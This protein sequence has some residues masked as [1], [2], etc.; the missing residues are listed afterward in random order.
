ARAALLIAL[1]DLG[2]IWALEEVTGALT[3]LADASISAAA[4]WLL[5]LEL[6]AGRLPGIDESALESG[7]GYILLAMGKLG[8]RELNFSSD[9]DLIAL[10]DDECFDGP[11][12]M[13]ARARY[14]HVTRQ[15][16]RML[17]ENTEDGYVFRTD[18]RLR[19]SPSTTPI[20]L[21]VSAAERYYEAE[22]R[23]W[24]RAAHIKARP[25]IDRRAGAAYLRTLQPFIW[26]RHLDFAAIEDAHDMLDR[27]REQKARF[28][29]GALPGHDVKLGPGGIREIEFFAQTRQLIMGGRDE[30]M[31]VPTTLGALDAL[32]A[33]GQ[34]APETRDTL[35][36]DYR[37]L[38][39]IE[40]RL[41]MIEDAQTHLIPKTSEAR[42]R[43]A[44][45]AGEDQPG[46][47]RRIAELLAR[48]HAICEPF[49][50]T[51]S[52]RPLIRFAALIAEENLVERGFERP[53]DAAR[54]ISRWHDGEIPATR[55][56][57]ARTLFRQIEPQIVERLSR[58]GSPDQA[59][60]HFDRFLS[61]L[62]AGVQL[63]SLFQANPNLLDLIIEICAA[64]PQLGQHLGRHP[65]T[66][67]ALLDQDFWEELPGEAAL[68]DDLGQILAGEDSYERVLDAARRWAREQW[69]RVSVQVLRA[70]I[71]EREAGAGFSRIAETFI[72]GLYPHVVA[73][74]ARRHGAPPG[75][76]MVVLAM[77]RLGSREMNAG[78]DLDLITIYDG[79]GV[80]AS[81]SP[82]PLPPSIY[83]PRLTQALMAALTAPTAEGALYEVDMRLRPSGRQGPVAVS[84]PAFEHY[85]IEKAWVWEHMALSRARVVAGS[86][87]LAPS[88]DR[89]IERALM[90]RKGQGEQVLAEAAMMRTRIIQAN[91]PLRENP[92]SLKHAAGG[93]ME[94][95]FLVQTGLLIAG[96]GRC[97]TQAA[98][99]LLAGALWLSS[100]EAHDLAE[101][102]KL[103]QCL[104]QI[105]RVALNG[106]LES[107]RM[108]TELQEILTRASGCA[109]FSLLETRLRDHQHR[110]AGI[111]ARVFDLNAAAT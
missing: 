32:V 51:G 6:R 98:L 64:A 82:R 90:S 94:I 17:S 39:E 14:I 92:W 91:R 7:A 12:I 43:V 13:E 95:E 21:S 34:I 80:E 2:G 46:F 18:L 58:A 103:L 84:L 41:Q 75:K 44:M 102:L 67:D 88:V 60:V 111:A 83:Y 77:G 86:V 1:A 27:I 96:L 73:E 85:Q 105:E 55:A 24:E 5:T 81:D 16:V 42:R 71:G 35:A 45:L 106:T 97:N 110:A 66:L 37:S 10:F 25:L 19:P 31:R 69:F 40:H 28:T 36:A 9:I 62:P 33:A 108:N 49:F 79:D 47:E 3:S 56:K 63:F 65:Q 93:L 68:A 52:E 99:P 74:F 29:I 109:D 26:R 87:G 54:L 70:L 38:R 57:R 4:R 61:G 59:L 53:L 48:V 50:T 22:G 78:S 20:C 11:E 23:T 89:I 104:Q 76:G 30:R 100:A 15:L 101:A 107:A 8:A 72:A